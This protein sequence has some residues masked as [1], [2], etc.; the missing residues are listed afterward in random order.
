V[1]VDAAHRARAVSD[2][3][4]LIT[5][6]VTARER[7]LGRDQVHAVAAA[8]AGGRA[9]SR[10]L[11]LAL[12]GRP[13][14]LADGRSPAP[15]AVANLLVALHDAG[16][17]DIPLPAC[18]RCGRQVR[19]FQR[20]GQDWYCTPCTR[21]GEPCAAC[22]K[23]RP[24]ASR[25]RAGRP[26][27]AKCPDDDG[28]DPVTVIHG[29]IIAL[30]PGAGR[31]TVAGAVRQAAPRPSYQQKLAWALEDNPA[32]LTG[33]GHL[34][35]L[36]AIPR[37]IEMLH[38]AGV[39]GV[40]RP[41]C[42]RCGRVVRI[43][44]P[45]DGV[46][47]CRTCIA[48]SRT[49]PC[50][51]CG[52]VREPVTR[53]GQGRPV[54]ANCFVIAPENL[55]ACTGCGRVRRVERRTA[56]GPL[57]SRCPSLP[58][59]A[60]SACGQT[61]PCGIS[62]ATGLPWCPPCQRRRAAC[63]ACGHHEP[64]AS[65]TLNR[66][67]CAGCTPP[68]PWAG[69]PVC[70]DPDHPSPGTCAR[71]IVNARLDELMGPDAGTLPPGLQTLRREIAG[72]EHAVTAMRWAAKPSI[73]PVLSGLADG[74]IPL[75][76]QALDGLPQR[77]ALAHL[78]QTLVATGA[79]PWRDEEMTRLEAFLHSLLD[80]Q[81]GPERRRLLH[82]Y[83]IWH[84]A[85]RIRS[86]NNGKPATRQ[87]ALLARRLA[88]GANAFL[89]WLDSAGLTMG[90]CQQAD[91]DRWLASGQ[92][93]YR[94]EAGRL[95]RWAHAARLTSCYLPSA[96]RWTGPSAILGGEDRWDIARRLL[97]DDT[98]KPEDRL[99]GLL[100]LLYA[101]GV[102]A[103]SRMTAGQVQASGDGTVRL[104]L[105]RAPVRLPE[106]AAS[107]ALAV[108]ANRKGH[109]TIGAARPSPWLFPGGQPGQPIS[110]ARLTL[111]LDALGISP[112]QARST[113]LFQ[114]AAEVPA[115]ILARTLGLSASVAVTWQRLSAG[116]WAAY[117]ADVSR[118]PPQQPVPA[119]HETPGQP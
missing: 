116:D 17:R 24:V 55:E 46:R 74:S 77:P 109:A 30:D 54:C 3:A 75:T 31:E 94:E 67:L 91:L 49:E 10:R 63:S 110:S 89:D 66:P 28:R 7:Q 39:A 76:H 98:L 52:A 70:S 90:T 85:R 103:I 11:A 50:A 102:T 19:G 86:R 71:C 82:R 15:R 62:R 60:C 27:C 105:G 97:H 51:R 29:I 113:A 58:V 45:L 26:R 119:R 112:R 6:L 115:A 33:D 5:D 1:T 118:R 21:R 25:D 99:A 88:R 72:A 101:Q 56:D 8:V 100:V 13:A 69:C 18:A 64:V 83:L 57:C 87:Q 38:G 32:L 78:R 111:R 9:K 114:L 104:Q 43:D 12:A 65:G 79:L 4:G 73:A 61:V 35:P 93:V 37:F 59:L 2:P 106:P 44:K 95:I 34:A 47:V 14:V 48:H 40:V 92:A 16:A 23:G 53:D 96:A 22:G 108:A 42:G 107:I 68:P 41:A 81:A 80:A 84:L 20:R 36:R 117:A